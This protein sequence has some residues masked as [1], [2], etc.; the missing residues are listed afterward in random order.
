MG[1]GQKIAGFFL[2][3]GGGDAIGKVDNIIERYAPGI[4]GKHDMIQE[5]VGVA[6]QSQ[7]SAR[8]H[9]QPMQSGFAILDG[10]VNG[11]NR[12]IRPGVTIGLIGGYMGWWELPPPD[13]VDPEIHSY[14][15][16]VLSFWF[17]SRTLTKDVPAAI[18]YLRGLRG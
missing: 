14:L 7:Q 16:L 4:Q 12:L 10:L 11:V 9:D 2:G 13:S 1:I 6:E 5:L 8:A 3:G 17:G 15:T 18:K